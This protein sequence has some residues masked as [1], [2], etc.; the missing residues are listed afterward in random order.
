MCAAHKG[1]LEEVEYRRARHVVSEIQRTYDAVEALGSG[2]YKKFG[3]LM[4]GSHNSL[5]SAL[6][7]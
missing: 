6:S 2:D 3:E 1:A 7:S 5:R 4:V